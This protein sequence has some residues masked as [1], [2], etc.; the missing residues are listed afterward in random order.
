MRRH[1]L[2][3]VGTPLA[4]VALL[5]APLR[6]TVACDMS[7]PAGHLADAVDALPAVE[8]QEAS[9]GAHAAHAAHPAHS[10]HVTPAEVSAEQAA[11]HPSA[12]TSE[13]LSPERSAPDGPMPAPCDDLASCAVAA[14]PPAS[15]ARGA[16]VTPPDAPRV[17]IADA[18]AAPVVGVDPPPPR[19]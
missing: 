1:L 8:S 16:I 5:V 10:E 13:H 19:T 11:Q 12:V 18:L 7:G 17:V 14:L 6:A 3:R 15:L 4:A 2:H 9:A